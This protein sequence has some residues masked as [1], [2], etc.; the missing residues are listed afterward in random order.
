MKRLYNTA[1]ALFL[2]LSLASC[3]KENEKLF[4][5]S[6]AERL[7]AALNKSTEI[8]T[9][10]P[11]GWLVQYYAG[12]GDEKLGGVSHIFEFGA[13][14]WVGITSELAPDSAYRSL[15][16]VISEQSAVL[17]FDTYNPVFHIFSE[18]QGFAK[19]HGEQGDYEFLILE[20]SA[21]EVILKGKRYGN[22]IVMQPFSG[23][24]TKRQY[25]R[26]VRALENMLDSYSDLEVFKGNQKIGSGVY[27]GVYDAYRI[28]YA[29]TP[30]D[31]VEQSFY[32]AYT[33][34]GITLYQ[35]ENIA[36]VAVSNFRW[37]IDKHA[38]VG[39]GSA[40]NLSIH[41]NISPKYSLYEGTYICEYIGWDNRGQDMAYS[42]IVNVRADKRGTSYIL[43]GL[44][45]YF[46]YAMK[47][48]RVKKTLVF[49][50]N[51]LL[52]DPQYEVILCP[53]LDGGNFSWTTTAGEYVGV[54][55]L[56]G[57][58]LVIRF[59]SDGSVG[60]A[61]GLLVLLFDLVEQALYLWDYDHFYKNMVMIK[62]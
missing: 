53:W 33:P 34:E 26:E 40:S 56:S 6:S 4:E 49:P 39:T 16:R 50:P 10:A 60:G 17:T 62:Q 44:S 21:E 2:M 41:A 57:E 52:V 54:D 13:D 47:F 32:A 25:L 15:Y 37:N 9:G 23:N 46:N 30:G 7:A 43:S 48:D 51:M 36:G 20:I 18:P 11:N 61:V 31:S 27:M 45:S 29:T 14:G 58:N 38:Y 5:A 55:D 24:K 42:K 22:R 35:Q 59:E 28:K 1:L 19:L 12:V 3:M 8:L